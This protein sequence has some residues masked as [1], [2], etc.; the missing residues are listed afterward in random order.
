MEIVGR[1][2]EVSILNDVQQKGF[3]SFKDKCLFGGR[4]WATEKI[5][6]VGYLEH[7][8]AHVYL[9]STRRPIHLD[10]CS[11][12]ALHAPWKLSSAHA[13]MLVGRPI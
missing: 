1:G 2:S 13:P 9:I 10:G 4:T 6:S 7:S 8:A 3:L 12:S 5:N 11:Y